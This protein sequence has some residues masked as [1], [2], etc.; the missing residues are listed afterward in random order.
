MRPPRAGPQHRCK[1]MTLIELLVAMVGAAVIAYT[2][3]MVFFS[4]LG[5]YNRYIWRL[6]PHDAATAAVSRLSKEL[7]A[8]ML[9]HDHADSALVAVDPLKD[10]NRDNV[11]TAGPNG[12]HLEQGEMV[13]FYLSDDTGALDAAGHDLWEAVKAV[14]ATEFVPKVMIAQNVH[15]EMNPVDPDTGLVRPM[16]K[17]WPDEVRLWGV[18]IWVTSAGTVHGATQPRTAHCEVYLRNL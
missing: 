7:R 6:P 13:A 16:F 9:I 11:L 15:P 3:S 14:G 2:I 1:G 17:Y 12:F 8:A 18:E 4:T 5:I 10:A